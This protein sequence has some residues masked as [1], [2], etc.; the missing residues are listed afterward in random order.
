MNAL[1]CQ[2]AIVGGGQIAASLVDGLLASGMEPNQFR[3]IEKA[4]DRINYWKSRE[5]IVSSDPLQVIKDDCKTVIL[6][7]KPQVAKEVMGEIQAALN[8]D[9]LLISLV[10]GLTLKN[11]ANSLNQE[12]TYL[13]KLIRVMPNTP[14]LVGKGSTGIYA[15]TNANQADR[16]LAEKIFESVGEVVWVNEESDLDAI[17]AVSGSGPAYVFKFMLALIEAG[18]SLGLSTEKSKRLVLQT[19]LGAAVMAMKNNRDLDEMINSVTSPGGTTEAAN[20][21]LSER[22]FSEILKDA[23]HSAHRRAKSLQEELS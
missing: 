1:P 13:P 14:M 8:P 19:V 22:G 9:V 12:R 16:N 2:I 20:K 11:L 10:A 21:I 18:Q 5:L 17:T 4:A 3:I 7:V 6:A 23:V 15:D